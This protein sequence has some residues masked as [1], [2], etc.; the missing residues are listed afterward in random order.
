VCTVGIRIQPESAIALL[1]RVSSPIV[2]H[3]SHQLPLSR[4]MISVWCG[5]RAL[6]V[7]V[8]PR[9]RSDEDHAQS[10][11]DPL[12]GEQLSPATVVDTAPNEATNPFLTRRLSSTSEQL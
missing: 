9:W 7:A 5:A 8:I 10:H 12:S 6:V 11:V 4:L 2:A 3:P 1:C